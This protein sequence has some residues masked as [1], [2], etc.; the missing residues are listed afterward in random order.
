MMS[1]D[2]NPPLIP[3]FGRNVRHSS[4]PAKSCSAIARSG[5]QGCGQRRLV[6]PVEAHTDWFGYR[7]LDLLI[8]CPNTARTIASSLR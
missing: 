6:G 8:A 5:G 2:R 1:P 3:L 7:F 4:A